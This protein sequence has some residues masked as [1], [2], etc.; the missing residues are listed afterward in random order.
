MK[1]PIRNIVRPKPKVKAQPKTLS[2]N[3]EEGLDFCN[4][5]PF[6]GL[7]EETATCNPNSKRLKFD[8]INHIPVPNWCGNNKELIKNLNNGK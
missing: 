4:E 1:Q 3:S 7:T 8:D 5:C 6:L 2:T